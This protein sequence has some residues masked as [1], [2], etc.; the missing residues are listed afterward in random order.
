[1]ARRSEVRL[2]VVGQ[3]KAGMAGQ[4]RRGWSRCGTARQVRHGVI[5][6]GVVRHG[7]YFYLTGEN[8]ERRTQV[9]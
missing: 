6:R 2:G 9:S 4:V 1:M 3:G 8:N 7:R 5:G